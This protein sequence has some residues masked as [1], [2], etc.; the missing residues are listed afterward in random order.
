MFLQQLYHYNKYGLTV[1]VLFI[2]AFLY[3]NVKWGLVATPVYQYGMFS[4]KYSVNDTQQVIHFYSGSESI[5]AENLHFSDRDML[6]G[7]VAKYEA[8]KTQNILLYNTIDGIYA[9]FGLKNLVKAGSY[10]N[11]VNDKSFSN[12][13]R[14]FLFHKMYNSD[15]DSVRYDYQLYQWQQGK[16]RPLSIKK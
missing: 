15:I 3:L 12:W 13:L 10:S 8:Q 2:A 16:M 7:M 6:F 5:P 1:F 11:N 4:G 14:I 9:R